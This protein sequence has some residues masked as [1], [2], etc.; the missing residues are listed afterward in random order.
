L[1]KSIE[2]LKV[3]KQYPAITALKDCTFTVEKG[4]VHGFLGPNGAGKSTTMK[5]ITGITRPTSGTVL[6]NGEDVTIENRKKFNVGYLPEL[7]PLYTHM[8]VE[9]YLKF[10][11]H[12]WQLPKK[13]LQ[14]N[15]DHVLKKCSI[16]DV[17]S[18]II[19]NLSKGYKQR[20]GLAQA[21]I[22]D[23]EIIILDEPMVGLDPKAII[24]IR[25]L[26]A[27]L[28]KDHTVLISTH[29]LHEVALICSHISIINNGSIVASGKLDEIKT[30]FTTK[31]TIRA[32]LTNWNKEIEASISEQFK[33]EQITTKY[34]NG[35]HTVIFQSAA[36]GDI[37]QE[38]S[39]AIIGKYRL[40]LLQFEEEKAELEHIFQKFTVNQ[41]N[42]GV[43]TN[44]ITN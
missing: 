19:G 1:T 2:L 7:P 12:L 25:D 43:N 35:V 33:M 10:V 14:H 16:A 38:L 5:I 39:Q 9:E 13:I 28:G 44:V 21:L 15:V 22:H 18:R 40:G 26:V 17:K 24:E 3:T 36:N 32:S 37:R 42:H 11:A 27:D 41:N 34:E 31:Q 23:P 30:G 4:Q 29:Q 20:V 8:K 6:I